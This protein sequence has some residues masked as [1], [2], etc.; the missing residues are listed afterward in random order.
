LSLGKSGTNKKAS[1]LN[2]HNQIGL[3]LGT[4]GTELTQ[5]LSKRFWGLQQGG[6]VTKQDSGLGKIRNRSDKRLKV[7]SL[8]TQRHDPWHHRSHD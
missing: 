3:E 7:Q 2:S 5:S 8:M 6:Y 1:R 4:D